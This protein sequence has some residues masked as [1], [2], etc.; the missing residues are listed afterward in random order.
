MW[1]SE[2]GIGEIWAFDT[3]EKKSSLGVVQTVCFQFRI[4]KWDFWDWQL[5]DFPSLILY[6]FILIEHISMWDRFI[7]AFQYVAH[8]R[9]CLMLWIFHIPSPYVYLIILYFADWD[10]LTWHVTFLITSSSWVWRCCYE[11]LYICTYHMWRAL[12]ICIARGNKPKCFR[13]RL[14]DHKAGPSKLHFVQVEEE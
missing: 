4:E 12:I 6:H 11:E 14:K 2:N 1:W 9:Y 8:L 3:L 5:M 13:S 10:S 7:F